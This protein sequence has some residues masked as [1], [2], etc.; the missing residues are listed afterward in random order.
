MNVGMYFCEKIHLV[1][2][3]HVRCFAKE[4]KFKGSLHFQQNSLQS[5]RQTKKKRLA[6]LSFDLPMLFEW[7]HPI[8]TD[9]KCLNE[10]NE[11]QCFI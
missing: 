6:W 7:V 8:V 1:K 11:A 5:Q 10:S 3:N 2:V 9:F 4:R